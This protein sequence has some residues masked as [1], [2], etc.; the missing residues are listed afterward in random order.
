M[1]NSVDSYDKTKE[2]LE[3]LYLKKRHKDALPGVFLD[4]T[5]YTSTLNQRSIFK[6][7]YHKAVNSMP[8]GAGCSSCE[9]LKP[10]AIR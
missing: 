10:C 1:G 7:W 4:I 3:E 2:Q 9:S 6:D 8:M 5:N